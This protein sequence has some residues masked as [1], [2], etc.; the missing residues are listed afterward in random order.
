MME[1]TRTGTITSVRWPARSWPSTIPST[2]EPSTNIEPREATAHTEKPNRRNAIHKTAST[3]AVHHCQWALAA[4]GGQQND[5][6][7]VNSQK[8]SLVNRQA[9]VVL[10]QTRR[11][12]DHLM[13][14]T[15]SNVNQ[16]DQM[17]ALEAQLDGLV[18]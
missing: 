15:V 2:T 14:K 9:Q 4:N 1:I 10:P 5:P 18:E 3:S 13:D 12:L 17:K 11:Q 7:V 8:A 6:E 16:D